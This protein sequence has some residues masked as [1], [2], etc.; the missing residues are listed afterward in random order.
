LL[1]GAGDGLTEEKI[2]EILD[3]LEE[4]EAVG[5]YLISE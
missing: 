4:G 2:D 5:E 3:A 1:A